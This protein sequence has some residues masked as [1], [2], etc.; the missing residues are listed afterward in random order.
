MALSNVSDLGR[1][2]LRIARFDQLWPIYPTLDE[3]L[4]AVAV[5]GRSMGPEASDPP[6]G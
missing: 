2:I 4:A 1:D 5:Q 6:A 3:A